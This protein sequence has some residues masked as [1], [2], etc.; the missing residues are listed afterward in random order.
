MAKDKLTRGEMYP[1]LLKA[2]DKMREEI[3]NDRKKK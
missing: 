1:L 2:A 3:K